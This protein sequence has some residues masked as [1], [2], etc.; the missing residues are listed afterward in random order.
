MIKCV[1]NSSILRSSLELVP[2]S[3]YD[4]IVENEFKN[5]CKRFDLNEY[6]IIMIIV[7]Q[8]ISLLDTHYESIW[9]GLNFYS[10]DC[11]DAYKN[12]YVKWVY[13]NNMID[14]RIETLC[15]DLKEYIK[16]NTC[17]NVTTNAC[18]TINDACKKHH[19][20]CVK[21]LL[22]NPFGC[23]A[24]MR[25]EIKYIYDYIK[26]NGNNYSSFSRFN[27][28]IIDYVC[29]C[30]GSLNII[31]YLFEVKKK[32]CTNNAVNHACYN[33]D[34]DIVKYL[35]ETKNKKCT[36]VTIDTAINKGH[37]D[38]VKYLFEVHN[39]DCSEDCVDRAITSGY[40]DIVKYLFEVQHKDCV[41]NCADSAIE[42][43][44]IDIVKY[45]FEVQ[46]KDCTIGSV[47]CAI[48]RGHTDIVKYLFEVQHKDFSSSDSLCKACIYGRIDIV[49]YLLEK[50]KKKFS[51]KMIRLAKEN[52]HINL[53]KYL[54]KVQNENNSCCTIC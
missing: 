48:I 21:Y 12:S 11:M 46:H 3:E 18:D 47:D 9:D 19:D 6:E 5:M 10:M 41:R 23:G 13:E 36:T 15:D 14:M 44:H 7:N 42:S 50:Q 8:D 49:K 30:G 27:A 25:D 40:I 29:I 22:D 38:I 2:E 37:L 53:V 26:E 33:G 52:D 31:K 51:R 24:T 45:L 39:C 17:I 1:T 20:G 4:M 28:C 32:D 34:L 43:G 16:H 35:I 54:T